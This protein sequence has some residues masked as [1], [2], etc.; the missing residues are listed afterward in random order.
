VCALNDLITTD[1]VMSR[2]DVPFQDYVRVGIAQFVE[3]QLHAL[4]GGGGGGGGGG[5]H[6]TIS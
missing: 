1:W 6:T 5:G 2:G 4:D 3:R